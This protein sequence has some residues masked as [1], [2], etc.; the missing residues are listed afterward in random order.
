MSWGGSVA[1]MIQ[2]LKNNKALLGK[3]YTYFDAKKDYL[4]ATHGMKI[5]YQ[6]ATK[7]E[8]RFVREKIKKQK[9]LD[10]IRVIIVL[11]IICPLLIYG[12]YK[13]TTSFDE[14]IKEQKI[15]RKK[16]DIEKYQFHINDGD[17]MISKGKWNNAIFQYTRASEIFPNEYDVQYRLTLAYTYKCQ[18]T[19]EECTKSD[20][21]VNRLL[22]YY[23]NDEK[24]KGL[25]V[26]L[27][28]KMK[29]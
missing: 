9:R 4:R 26:S 15:I 13:I 14:E 16:K 10:R 2:S 22:T 3:R 18:Y 24:V 11:S 17:Y 6:K 12:T 20:S 5:T 7:E 8:L 25:R 21:L 28:D 27:D 1:A 29:D 23:P 19:N